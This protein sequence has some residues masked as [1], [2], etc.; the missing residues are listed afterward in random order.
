M[1]QLCFFRN[2]PSQAQDLGFP[3]FGNE[4]DIEINEFINTID[5]DF[6]LILITERYK[7]SKILLADLLCLP[8]RSITTLV[9]EKKQTNYRVSLSSFFSE[10]WFELTFSSVQ[11][12]TRGDPVILDV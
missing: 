6:D 1:L 7:E 4:T 12:S 5:Q 10:K 9:E 2:G 8:L 11:L 3:P